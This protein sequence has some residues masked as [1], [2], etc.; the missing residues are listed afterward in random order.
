LPSTW[1][2]SASRARNIKGSYVAYVASMSLRCRF[3][4]AWEAAMSLMSLFLHR[5]PKNFLPTIIKPYQVLKLREK[6]AIIARERKIATYFLYPQ[7]TYREKGIASVE[8]TV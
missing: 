1:A 3:E 6:R 7:K 4:S 5:F 2:R 8:R